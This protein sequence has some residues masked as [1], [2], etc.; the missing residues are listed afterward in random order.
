MIFS[1]GDPS[2]YV[3]RVITGA[4]RS[5]RLFADGRRHIGEFF[6]PGDFVALDAV[7]HYRFIAEAVTDATLW[8]YPRAAIEKLASVEP[9]FGKR[10]LD[11]LSRQ[12]VAAQEQML[13]LGRKTATERVA[14]FLVIMAARSKDSEHV[15]LQ[16]TRSDIADHLGLT[17]ET[18][19]RAFSRLKMEGLIGLEGAANV[20]VQDGAALEGLAE[21]A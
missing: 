4:V 8:R 11:L 18:V 21:A 15:S 2:R 20:T 7:D 9:S 10:L 13:L 16:M 3:F 6:L 5:C 14:A 12:L 1:E 17:T 19:S